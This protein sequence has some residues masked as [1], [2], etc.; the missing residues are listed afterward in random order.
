M[1]YSI[2][3]FFDLAKLGRFNCFFISIFFKRHYVIILLTILLFSLFSRPLSAKSTEIVFWHSFS[4]QLG[5]KLTNLVDEFNHSQTK[6]FIKPVYKGDYISA[7]TSFAAAFQA[8]QSPALVQVFEVG[9]ASMLMPIGVIKPAEEILREQGIRL[10]KESFFPAVRDF[11]SESG[12]LQALP[13]NTSVPVI[14]YNADLLRQVGY[15]EDNFPKTWDD[16]ELLAAKLHRAGSACVYTTAFP[17]W[18]QIESFAALHGLPLIDSRTDQANFN[19]P[20][21]VK[22]LTR[23]KRWQSK[24]YFEYGGRNNDATVLFTSGR[25]ALF[26]QS[27]GGYNSLVGL[28]KFHLGV[29]QLP[30]DQQVSSHRYPNVV[31]GAAL[32][33]IRGHPKAVYAGIAEFYEYLMQPKVQQQWYEQTGYI[34]LG[35]SGIYESIQTNSQH[36]TLLIAEHDLADDPK[37]PVLK[38]QRG[39]LNFLRTINDEAMEAIFAGIKT[40]EQAMDDAMLRADYAVMRFQ[41][42]TQWA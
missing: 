24:H 30:I 33:A 19:R 17:A 2:L 16:L 32:W 23:L 40:P 5:D 11:Y 31:G 22:H 13:F 26:S 6:Y 42:N 18:I 7:L 39:P 35:V 28:V 10:P 1:N 38:I 29:A 34:P 37:Y 20:A 21:I 4:G 15:D 14:F 9:T 41:R 36:P 27:S 12:Q 8:K 3:E 25:C